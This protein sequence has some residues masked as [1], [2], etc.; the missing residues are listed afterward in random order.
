MTKDTKKIAESVT[1][2]FTAA[3]F[4]SGWFE[5]RGTG[6]VTVWA[7]ARSSAELL[8]LVDAGSL[9]TV[10]NN[11]LMKIMKHLDM[12]RGHMDFIEY[13]GAESDRVYGLAMRRFT[14][15]EDTEMILTKRVGLNKEMP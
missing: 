14:P 10:A 6:M 2:S 12:K 9:I 13:V 3:R 1:R 11:H 8:S 5:S 15:L 7:K 4:F